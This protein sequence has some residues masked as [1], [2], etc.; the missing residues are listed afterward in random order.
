[1]CEYSTRQGTRRGARSQKGTDLD[2]PRPLPKAVEA[3]LVRDLGGVHG[4]GQILLVG[5]DEEE[6]VA[7]L[8]LVEHALQLLAGLRDTFP[9]VGVDDEDDA[10][11]VLEVCGRVRERAAGAQAEA[12]LE[13]ADTSDAGGTTRTMPPERTDLVL[14][15]DVP[16]GEGDVLVLYRLNVET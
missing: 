12:E 7:E 6:G 16:D 9:V 4:V 10:L 8:V 2:E 14:S 15:S 13:S 3:E 1:M 5:E 11:R